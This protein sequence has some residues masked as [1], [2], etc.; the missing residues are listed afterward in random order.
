MASIGHLA[1]GLLA[2]RLH[3]GADSPA[4]PRASVGTMLTFA[5][6]AALPDFDVLGVACGLPDEGVGGH[7]GASHS[8]V[9]AMAVGLVAALIARRFGWPVLRTAV[10]ATLAVASHALLDAVGEGGRGIPLL[11]PLS[12]ARFMS[13][14]RVLPD[15]PRGLKMLSR[16]GLL[17]LAI[18]FLIFFPLTAFALW[19]ARQAFRRRRT[20]TETAT[21]VVETATALATEVAPAL[22]ARATPALAANPLQR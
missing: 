14:W 19:P 12:D 5:V 11:W 21:I 18:E 6:L 13:P 16:P 3:G 17:D 10:V 7:R 1:V 9:L 22:A 15:A 20:A 8:F 4:R 2:G